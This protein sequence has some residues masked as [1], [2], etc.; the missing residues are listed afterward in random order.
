[1]ASSPPLEPTISPNTSNQ[2]LEIAIFFNVVV[3]SGNY[4]FED[5]NPLTALKARI[6][7]YA[8]GHIRFLLKALS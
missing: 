3:S 6:V 4:F 8:L 1:M 7:S 5:D 2:N